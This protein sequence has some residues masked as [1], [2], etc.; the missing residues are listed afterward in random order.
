MAEQNILEHMGLAAQKA[1]WQLAGTTSA[2]RNDLLSTIAQKL[3]AHTA[4]IIEANALDLAAAKADGMSDAMLDRLALTPQRLEGI[5]ADIYHVISLP[6]P[7]GELIDGKTLDNGLNLMRRRVPL[8]VIGAIYEARPNVTI[9]IATLCVK[10]AN[11]VILRGGKETTHSNKI[12]VSLIQEAL[13]ECGFSSDVVQSINNPDRA[14]VAALLRLDKYVDMIIPRGGAKLQQLCKETSTIPVIIGGIG[15]CHIF[16]D[17]TANVQKS[18]ELIINAKVQRPSTCNSVET[19][20]VHADIA[21]DFLPQL[22]Q[23]LTKHGVTMHAAPNAIKQLQHNHANVV[24]VTEENFAS[25]WLSLDINVAVV[26]GLDGAVDHIRKYGTNHSEA[27]LTSDMSNANKFVS[28]IDAAAV[29]VNASTRFT[30]GGQFNLGAEVAVSTQKLHA[31]GPMGLEALTSYKW[32][33]YGD[34]AKRV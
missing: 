25:E 18:L 29:F 20:L 28:Q 4:Q 3:S 2:Q 15:V 26:A 9:D 32:V 34:Y 33:A 6:D 10:T 14:L 19:V 7:V 13:A 11:A 23:E 8:G 31:R 5:I 30:D 1:A 21:E 27:I 12:L 24:A 16:V 22:S 17:A